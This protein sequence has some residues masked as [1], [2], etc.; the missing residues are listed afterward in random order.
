MA[1]MKRFY[2]I[3]AGVLA[4]VFV[5]GT[6]FSWA[7]Q[8]N[9]TPK[10]ETSSM[11][12]TK[13]GALD[14]PLPPIGHSLFIAL[15]TRSGD[16]VRATLASGDAP[17]DL[18]L[19]DADG[20]SLRQLLTYSTGK[21]EFQFI[22]PAGAIA[23]KLDRA[24]TD[25]IPYP[26]HDNALAGQGDESAASATFQLSI[27]NQVEPARQ[28]ARPEG[29]QSPMIAGIANDIAAGKDTDGFWHDVKTAGSPII[30]RGITAP[31]T[32][33]MTFVY[34]GASRN[35]RLFGA[36]SGNH[37]YLQQLAKSDIWFKSFTVPDSTRLSYQLAPD[38]PDL[39]GSPRDRRIAILSTAQM[40][41]LNQHPWPETGADRFNTQST[42][43]L[44][45]APMQPGVLAG[46][47]NAAIGQGTLTRHILTSEI[48]HNQREAF[49]YLPPDFDAQNP[50]NILLFAFDARTYL[51]KIQTQAILDNLIGA[52]QL[53]PVVA[54][55]LA[56][57]DADA[58]ARELPANPTFADA[59][60]QEFLPWVAAQTGITANPARTIIAGS[61]YGGLAAVTVALRHP[62]VFGNAL[63]MSGSF[64]WHPANSLADR[65]EYVVSQ[66]VE[67]PVV[68]VRI[69]L[70]A[71]LF[72]TGH[73]GVGGIIDTNR[74][75]RDVLHA[76]NY[77]VQ[78]REY[79]GGHDH[80]VWRGVLGDGLLALFGKDTP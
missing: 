74:H 69:F 58:R 26:V 51:G 7:Q 47:K 35:V 4:A 29:Y 9:N 66:V 64:W 44:E 53:P 77:D 36:P 11:T 1:P 25:F 30:E 21:G 76:R 38:V 71:G 27:I 32:V 14:A 48:L 31:G 55:F 61:S 20:K 78:Y 13:D 12:L 22:A 50:D 54:I 62:Q 39:P 63:S 59:M 42:V 40:D 2:L 17:V 18:R 3:M 33:L 46:E 43:T 28:V 79:A 41:P 73:S 45:N 49:I 72:E 10:P 15:D 75:L 52:D 5:T 23:L 60:A 6:A 19:V 34:R 80:F 65:Q 56:N 24:S 57:P 68:P 8:A 16:Y 70:G 67:N 37:E